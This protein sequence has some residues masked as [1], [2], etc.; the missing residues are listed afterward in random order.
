MEI[1]TLVNKFVLLLVLLS[2]T[3]YAEDSKLSTEELKQVIYSLDV[4]IV[5]QCF[6][7]YR[8]LKD[9]V[10]TETFHNKYMLMSKSLG[11]EPM[12][13]M[14]ELGIAAGHRQ[15]L[16]QTVIERELVSTAAEAAKMFSSN[17]LN[18]LELPNTWGK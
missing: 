12:R 6:E 10:L 18:K 16:Y 17:C 11:N 8:T 13:S 1:M 7:D 14:F 3:A 5:G 9:P 2:F 4:L 15:S